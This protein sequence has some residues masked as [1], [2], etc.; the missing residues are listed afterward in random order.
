MNQHTEALRGIGSELTDEGSYADALICFN[1]ALA[2]DSGDG[3]TWYKKGTVLKKLTRHY[4]AIVC[5]D[6]AIKI[7]PLYDRA[8]NNK[9]LILNGLNAPNEMLKRNPRLSRA[10]KFS[11]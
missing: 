9:R 11:H 4:E 1:K 6:K 2:I 8:R 10:V 7:E 3:D 5:F